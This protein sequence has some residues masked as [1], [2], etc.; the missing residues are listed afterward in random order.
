MDPLVI[1]EL[2]ITEGTDAVGLKLLWK[3]AEIHGLKDIKMT[4][5]E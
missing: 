1:P 3:N 4:N 2:R 5:A